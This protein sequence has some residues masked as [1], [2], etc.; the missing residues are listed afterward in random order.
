MTRRER[1]EARLQ[2]RQEWAAG[3]ERKSAQAF[4]ASRKATEGIPFGQ[5]ILVG[6]HSEG[7]HRRAVEKSWNKLG[8]GVEH[9]KM[10]E[11]HDAKAG[12][13]AHALD[14][15]IFSDDPDAIEAIEAR[16]VSLE[17]QREDARK[18]GAAWRKAKKPKST[19]SEGWKRVAEILGWTDGAVALI[20]ARRDCASE[21]GFLN[22][23]PVPS[24]VLSNLGGNISRL[25]K[26]VEHIKILQSR[27][28]RAEAA[29][30]GIC[31]ATRDDYAQITFADK[32]E[33]A[34]I[35][36]LKAAGFHWSGG[37]WFGS[38]S[39]IPAEVKS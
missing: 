14:S 36:A 31:I 15:S 17:K 24:Y 27:A 28:A 8:Q 25:K 38:A 29:P 26:R 2:K 7:H 34:T 33:R 12:G 1:L 23:G 10:A 16:I 32:P 6:H 11:H 13:I 5:P 9:A 21:E 19:D 18:I 20:K 4:D 22:R 30:G 37:S 39:K 35:E 3:R